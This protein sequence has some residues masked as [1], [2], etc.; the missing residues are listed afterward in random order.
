MREARITLSD[1]IMDVFKRM[2]EGNPGALTVMAEMLEKGA[3]IDPQGFMGGLGAIL[4]LDTHGIYGS[5]IWMLYKDVCNQSI[6]S[7]LAIL[8]AC[9]LGFLRESD[10][11]H[12]IDNYG[13]G[14]DMD[15]LVKQVKQRLEKFAKEGE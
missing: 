11:I 12:A 9:Q 1:S 6:I 2:S 15:A 14:I 8:R 7:T 13:A 4:S 10:M 5:R 3:S